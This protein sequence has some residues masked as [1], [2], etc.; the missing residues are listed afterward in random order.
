[1]PLSESDQKAFQ[2]LRKIIDE[3]APSYETGVQTTILGKQPDGWRNLLTKFDFVCKGRTVPDP[4]LHKYPDVIINRRHINAVGVSENLQRL[5]QEAKLETGA[6][7]GH[8]SM[9]TRMGHHESFRSWRR[10]WSQ[11]PGDIVYFDRAEGQFQ[12][13]LPGTSLIARDAPYYPT[14]GHAFLD[15]FGSRPI[16]D[17]DWL[18]GQV[19]VVIPDFRARISKL[20]VGRDYV[21]AEFECALCQP[22]DLLVKTYAENSGRRLVQETVE[23]AKPIIEMNLEDRA[24]FAAIALL[25]K[26]TGEL[27]HEKSFDEKRGWVDEDVVVKMA[28]QEIE[29]MLLLGETETVEFREKIEPVRLAKTI[30]AFANTRGGTIIVGVDDNHRVV[31]CDLKGL[32]DT[33]TNVVRG[34]CDRPPDVS[35]EVVEYQERTLFL[36]RVAES[37]AKVHVEKEHGPLIR[38]NATNRT[39]TS[40]ELDR[41]YERRNNSG[42]LSGFGRP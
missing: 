6:E 13:G 17:S 21:R 36:V 35:M 34:R 28:E 33:V 19:I 30:V 11:W 4:V 16:N 5:L 20:T 22:E 40:Y 7:P 25:S 1:M 15:L 27:L 39:P 31:G 41:L 2:Q 23:L 10:E 29:Q 32:E 14:A 37:K 3:R 8:V 9:A 24:T 42:I 12:S 26:S 38:A 18:R